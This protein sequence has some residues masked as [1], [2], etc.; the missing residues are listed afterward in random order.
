M[1]NLTAPVS[2]FSGDTSIVDTVAQHPVGTQAR[3]KNGEV[4]EYC[5]GVAS[6]VAGSWVVIGANNAL[7]LTTTGLA[8]RVGIAM[9]ALVASTYGWVQV[10]GFNTIALA[11][12]NGT[13]TSGGGELQANSTVPGYVVATGTSTGSA[14]GDYILGAF[15]Y[16]AQPSSAN[17]L[18]DS[19]FLNFPFIAKASALAVTS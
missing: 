2:S 12:S 10:Y 8:G 3:G 13:I 4:F 1:A 9:A 5:S 15:S 14:T 16:G 19:V 11:S 18:L 6:C 17:D 7:T